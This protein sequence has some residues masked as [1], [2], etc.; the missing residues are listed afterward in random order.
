MASAGETLCEIPD[1]NIAAEKDKL[2]PEKILKEITE[3]FGSVVGGAFQGEKNV[4]LL[5]ARVDATIFI[6]CFMLSLVFAS[7]QF[8][9][10][11]VESFST[12][13]LLY[14]RLSKS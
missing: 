5:L 9:G 10:D 3:D 2:S 4:V 11:R 13:T 12:L 7:F 6:V 1:Q 8:Y 14:C